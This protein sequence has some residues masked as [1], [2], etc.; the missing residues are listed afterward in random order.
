M[1][2][3]LGAVIAIVFTIDTNVALERNP[4]AD[5]Q[6]L[7]AEKRRQRKAS[8]QQ[9]AANFHAA[10]KAQKKA[11]KAHQAYLKSPAHH[12]EMMR[13]GNKMAQ[14]AR[15]SNEDNYDIS[16][17][18]EMHCGMTVPFADLGYKNT[19]DVR[20]IFHLPHAPEAFLQGG[21]SMAAPNAGATQVLKDEGRS[22]TGTVNSVE[23]DKTVT[24]YVKVFKDGYSFSLCAKDSMYDF[25][26]K[27]GDNKDQFK[28]HHL[29]VSIV[30]YSEIVLKE[31]QK[32]MSPKI[33]F[34]FCRTVPDMVY[35]G[36]RAGTDCYC[37]PFYTK[38]ESGS[39]ICDHTCPG[40]PTQ[41]CGGK[42]KSQL[43]EMHM[44][45][46]TAGDLLYS[47][48]NAEQELVYMYD[49]VFMTDKIAKWLH[50]SGHKL[51]KIA[52]LGG[53]PGA[54]DLGQL[55]IKEA[56][57]LFDASTGWG[58]C[59][60]QYVS[61]LKLYN[62][63]KPLY[64][65]DFSF[66][67]EVQSAEDSIMM[68][69]NLKTKLH[70]CAK[71]SEGPIEDT[72]PFYFEFMTALD[73]ADFQQKLDKFADGL[74]GYYPALY[75]MN[76]MAEPE[77]S[78]CTGRPVGKPMPLPLSGCAEACNR[79][80]TP[81]NRCTA[82]QYFQIQEGDEQMPLCFLFR[83]IETIK[84]YRCD[85]LPSLTQ[86]GAVLRGTTASNEKKTNQTREEMEICEK[87]KHAKRFSGMSCEA[88]FGK[89]S[90][91]IKACPNECDDNQGMKHTALCM[92]RLSASV[93]KVDVKPV[94]KCFGSGN[95]AADQSN[96]DFMLVDFGTD[97]SGGAGPKIEGDIDIGGTVIE[98]PY[99]FVWTPGPA[100][101]R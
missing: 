40:N 71:R 96:A 98:E 83:E 85:M 90:K 22:I 78:T 88:I 20:D 41:M 55:A 93:P 7:V 62:E 91:V 10:A 45:A 75:S 76:P 56:G 26:D 12:T 61:L 28:K 15:R 52:G 21:P 67:K 38:A 97:A 32:P 50:D 43:F 36:V 73:E 94:R 19:N 81:P 65:A 1:F 23:K 5:W 95:G 30:K 84:S 39:E 13:R 34:E 89:R 70:W 58:V 14:R 31:N 60:G 57:S 18:N 64:D 100:G 66:A 86:K 82:F 8:P 92:T 2:G 59:K 46:D 33:C 29:N 47:A 101:A 51:Q 16:P 99:G 42:T 72:Y 80:I 27:Y 49:T 87:V 4:D 69:D 17:Q 6:K 37:M 48:V 44:C 79:Q 74:V 53:D 54:A 77:M 11:A 68:M 63:A 35:F 3:G 24:P 9:I 25:G